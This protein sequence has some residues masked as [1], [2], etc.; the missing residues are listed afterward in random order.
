MRRVRTAH[1]VRLHLL[2]RHRGRINIG[3]D[4]VD[5]FDIR[6][7]LGATL[8]AQQLFRDGASSDA[9]DRFPGTR[10]PA[11]LPIANTIFGVVRII[12]VRGPVEMLKRRIVLGFGIGIPHQDGDGCT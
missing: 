2:L 5:L 11:T 12:G 8:L 3:V 6:H 1:D 7:D 10:P 4:F 9:P